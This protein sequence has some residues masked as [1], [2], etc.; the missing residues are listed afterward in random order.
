VIPVERLFEISREMDRLFE[1]EAG[2]KGNGEASWIPPMDVF[3]TGDEVLCQLEV[4][5][6]SRENIDIRVEG[7]LLTIAGEKKYEQRQDQKETGYRHFE[8]RYG[9][10][11]RSFTLPRTVDTER[12]KARYENG[13]LTV[14]LPKAE[15]AKPRKIMIEEPS[16]SHQIKQ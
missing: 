1:N 12:V 15:Q 10:F 3:E 2:S 7:N 14:A 13:I 16:T 4:P 11:E 6:L 9:R 8:R 5:G